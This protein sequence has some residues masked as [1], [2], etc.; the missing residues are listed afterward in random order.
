MKVKKFFLSL[1]CL[2]LF[3]NLHQYL[4]SQTRIDGSF[5]VKLR[6]VSP[7]VEKNYSLYI[8]SNYIQTIPNELM[9]GLHP[10]N[11][12]SKLW[13][14]TLVDFC[15][16]NG[17]LLACPDGGP[18]GFIDDP[19]DQIFTDALL[20][21]V[22]TWYNINQS[23]IFIMGFSWGGRT[24]YTYGLENYKWFAGFLPIGAYIDNDFNINSLLPHAS[25][26]PFYIIHG[27]EDNPEIHFYPIR[28]ALVASGAIVNWKL[29]DGVG[30]TVNFAGRDSIFTAAF[31]WLDSVSSVITN[32]EFQKDEI[33]L[34]QSVTLFQNIPNP[35]NAGTEIRYQIQLEGWIRVKIFTILGEEII[36]I[37]DNNQQPGSYT[38]YWDG[39]DS[40]A[41]P[42][43]S[44]IYVI[45][46]EF[47]DFVAHK[48]MLVI[49]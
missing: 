31:T 25:N 42:V 8:P 9:L 48:K 22:L 18:D 21:S 45:R 19:I 12:T 16:Q 24:T 30:H 35:F 39:T 6:P 40:N 36:T 46:M 34:P 47:E 32:I 41:M 28:D 38:L 26:K 29:L 43:A 4:C 13:C 10:Y 33:C 37:I 15:E 11:S 3:F 7:P 20:D 44:G 27:T 17:L 49:R 23:K 2:F 5:S 14:N 1:V